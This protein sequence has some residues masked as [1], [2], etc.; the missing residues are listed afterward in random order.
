LCVGAAPAF[1]Q[2]GQIGMFRTASGIICQVYDQ[3]G[4]VSIPV[5]HVLTPG[6]TACQFSAPLPGCWTN[7]I[8][9]S[10]TAVFPVTIG[11]S[12]AGVAVGYGACLG[13]PIH[14]L[15]INV[16]SQT[17]ITDP[18]ACCGWPV[19]PDPNVV[20]GKIEVV[21]CVNDLLYADGV[22]SYVVAGEGNQCEDCTTATEQSTWGAVKALYRD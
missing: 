21:D 3:A 7:A 8:F 4:L 13:S 11:S 5:V 9:L 12:Q 10:D 19:L 14:V 15:T 1:G 2:G 20:S 17:P 16:F 6:A 22:M 18:Y